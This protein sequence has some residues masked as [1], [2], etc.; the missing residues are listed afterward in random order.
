MA[1]DGI[2]GAFDHVTCKWPLAI[3]DKKVETRV[4]SYSCII[5]EDLIV[6]RLALSD[7]NFDIN[8]SKGWRELSSLISEFHFYFVI[9]YSRIN[10]DTCVFIKYLLEFVDI[11][12]LLTSYI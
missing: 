10:E 9:F 12:G 3:Y 6:S 1:T 8:F 2:L 7:I 4:M 11:L 5:S